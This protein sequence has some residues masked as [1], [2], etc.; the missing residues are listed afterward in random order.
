MTTT[1][2]RTERSQL[3]PQKPVLTPCA[4][5]HISSGHKL[6]I[7]TELT[8]SAAP[9]LLHIMGSILT[10]QQKSRT[11]EPFCDLRPIAN[12]SHFRSTRL[13]GAAQ[14]TAHLI[15]S[16]FRLFSLIRKYSSAPLP[17]QFPLLHTHIGILARRPVSCTFKLNF[18]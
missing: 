4:P 18:P 14:P 15:R 7:T 6:N 5:V 11:Q 8:T 2:A 16:T 10:A 3:V 17:A 12:S 13:Y 1:H 9:S